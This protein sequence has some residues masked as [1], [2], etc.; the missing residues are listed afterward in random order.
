MGHRMVG[1][2]QCCKLFVF[3]GDR[4]LAI[5]MWAY[6]PVRITGILVK[7]LCTKFQQCRLLNYFV[8]VDLVT[9]PKITALLRQCICNRTWQSKNG[10][11]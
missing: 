3:R 1:N 5:G 9:S 4:Q 6:T 2:N 8:T 7:I 11:F 10:T